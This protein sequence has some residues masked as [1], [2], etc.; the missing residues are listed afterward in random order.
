M[1]WNRSLTIIGIL[2]WIGVIALLVWAGGQNPTPRPVA[3]LAYS[4][5]MSKL[6]AGQ[7]KTATIDGHK[8]EGTLTNSARYSTLTPDDPSLPTQLLRHRVHVVV[9]PPE[10]GSVFLTL[11]TWVPFL[12]IAAIWIFVLFSSRGQTGGR[13]GFGKSRAKLITPTQTHPVTFA[14]VAGIDEARSELQEIVEFLKS[15][16]KFERL[17]GRIPKG[18]LLVGPPGTGKTL[19]A[20]AIAGEAQVPFF[21]ISGSEFVEMFV[22]VGASRVRDL[23]E[24]AKKSA[25]CIVFVDEIDAVGRKRGLG[26]SGTND[27]REQTLNQLLVE[28]DGFDTREGVILL[29]ATNRPDVL[30]PALLRPGRFDRRIQLSNPDI[31][32]R[33]QILLV[34]VRKVP[35]APDVDIRALAR[36]TPGL[37]GADLANLVNEAALLAAHRNEAQVSAGDFDD[38]KDKIMMGSERRS[39][40]MSAKE[41]K[42]TAV[43]ESGHALVTLYSPD[44]DPLH[45]VTI[46]PHGRA[47]GATLSLP[48]RDRFGYSRRELTTRLA[49]LFAGRVAEEFYFG[50]NDTTTGASDDIKQAT[51]LARRMVCEFGFSSKVGLVSYEDDE[52]GSGYESFLSGRKTMSNETAARIDEEISR[53]TNDAAQSAREILSGHRAELDRLVGALLEHETLTGAQITEIVQPNLPMVPDKSDLLTAA[54]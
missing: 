8:I 34:H 30:D 6:D 49:I 26:Y 14:D 35:L 53:L 22:G 38:A 41:R 43:H 39:L 32:G 11:L 24:Q 13:F 42:I 10:P 31:T 46:I 4:D 1:T 7:I 29:A 5:F 27:E 25:P 20:R 12:L 15:P 33:E 2:V 16:Q 28:M 45:K 23:F 18:C 19:L 54:Q 3:A 17:G 48:E 44:H 51:E 36:G 50:S 37:S 9:S 40:V 52:H 47:L 21:S